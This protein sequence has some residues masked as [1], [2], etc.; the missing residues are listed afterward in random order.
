MA[1]RWQLPA[2]L[3][4][5]GLKFGRVAHRVYFLAIVLLP[6]SSFWASTKATYFHH[7][8]NH[9]QKWNEYPDPRRYAILLKQNPALD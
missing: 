2:A 6:S 9:D 4:V 7:H 5:P 3:G 1:S 8:R